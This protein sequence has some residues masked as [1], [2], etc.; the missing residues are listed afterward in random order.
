MI[1]KVVIGVVLIAHGIGHV[2]GW[3][4]IL[5]WAKSAGWTGDSWVLTRTVGSG[6]THALA[7]ALLPPGRGLAG[8]VTGPLR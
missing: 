2:L 5:G 7:F 8:R 1:L 6:P 4:P 3:F